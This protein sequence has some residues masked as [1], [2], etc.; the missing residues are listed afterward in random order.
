MALLNT[1]ETE[2]AYRVT[3]PLIT[4]DGSRDFE[5]REAAEKFAA[6]K[7]ENPGRYGTVNSW[8]L[9]RVEEITA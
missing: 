5:T 4:Q 9:V 8:R 6:D 1:R 3:Y 7:R 2:M